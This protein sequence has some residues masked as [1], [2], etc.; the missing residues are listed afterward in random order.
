MIEVNCK[1][2]KYKHKRWTDPTKTNNINQVNNRDS[3]VTLS[4]FL[5]AEFLPHSR[6]RCSLM[7]WSSL[8]KW[9]IL[10]MA[11]WLPPHSC[12]LDCADSTSVESI[13]N[14]KKS[15]FKAAWHAQCVHDILKKKKA[16]R[17]KLLDNA[18]SKVSDQVSYVST[19]SAHPCLRHSRQAPWCVWRCRWENH[20]K[21]ILSLRW[22]SDR[23]PYP[24]HYWEKTQETVSSFYRWIL[25][26]FVEATFGW[27][28]TSN[29]L[30]AKW[31]H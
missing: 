31:M 28:P 10:S 19:R 11:A 3:C 21:T 16:A 8:P 12:L 6:R 22:W 23:P 27:N 2:L 1:C 30:L 15:V 17:K 13:Q 9:I 18:T 5:L 4:I 29:L 7:L 26:G 20:W 25:F 24:H 14:E